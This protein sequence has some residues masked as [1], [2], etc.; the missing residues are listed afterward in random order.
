MAEVVGGHLPRR[1]VHLLHEPVVD[2]LLERRD[3]L[4][5]APSAGLADGVEPERATEHGRRREHL[6]RELGERLH[7]RPDELARGRREAPGGRLRRRRGLERGEVLNEQEGHALGLLVEPAHQLVV[8]GC[9]AAWPPPALPPPP[10]SGAQVAW[11]RPPRR[12][13][14]RAITRRSPGSRGRR[15]ARTQEQRPPARACARCSRAGVSVPA[16]AHW[17]SSRKTMPGSTGPLRRPP[18]ASRSCPPGTGPRLLARR[19]P[20]AAAGRPAARPAR[21]AGA[22]PRRARGRAP[23]PAIRRRGARVP[24]SASTTG[25]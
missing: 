4:V 6:A 3:R 17:R 1:H 10:G 7:T 19:A 8:R 9:R 22:P 18:G 15:Q 14:P 23:R 2:Q 16:S 12:A 11:C 5:L 24:R 25:A 13:P 21:A 20:A